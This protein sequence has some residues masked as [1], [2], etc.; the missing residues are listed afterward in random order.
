MLNEPKF[1]ELYQRQR[2]SGLTVR[3][4]CSNEG[5]AE[6]TFYYWRKKRRKRSGAHNFIPLV[7]Q[8]SG[9]FSTQADSKRILPLKNNGEEEN[10]MLLELVYPNGTK[11]RIKNDIDLAHLRALICLFD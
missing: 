1:L 5:I 4:F 8:P 7:V 2:E 10:D 3:E 9:G 6:S 11:L